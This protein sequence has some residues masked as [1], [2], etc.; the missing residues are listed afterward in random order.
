MEIGEDLT[1]RY[2]THT[3]KVGFDATLIRLRNDDRSNFGGV[4]TFGAGVERDAGGDVVLDA[5][6]VP[7]ALDSLERYRRTLLGLPG[8]GPSQFTINRGD[9]LIGLSDKRM[10][11]FV[12]DDW[13]F[14]DR[15]TLSAG[16]RH[17]IQS[18]L[19]QT[20]TLAPRLSF[21]FIP[22]EAE[23]STIRIGVGVFTEPVGIGVTFDT[24]Q[25]DA[26]HQQQLIVS[27]P[28]FFFDIPPDLSGELAPVSATYVKAPDLRAPRS[29]VASLSY[30][31]ELPDHDR[32]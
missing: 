4:F 30:E 6:G 26:S 15:A 16:L 1:F 10:A 19:A 8:N 21:A 3:F 14:S 12:Q 17:D 28:G 23:A 31:R 22:D 5:A 11:W 2:R 32:L 24:I 13:S 7:I 20:W 29:L 27:N 9:P 18:D 25:F